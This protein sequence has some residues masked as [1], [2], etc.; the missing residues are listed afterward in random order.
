[1]LCVAKCLIH[2]LIE[3]RKETQLYRFFFLCGGGWGGGGG[4]DRRTKNDVSL[5]KVTTGLFLF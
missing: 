4:E 2:D 3:C 5:E 1:M